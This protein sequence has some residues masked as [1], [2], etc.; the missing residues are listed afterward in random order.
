MFQK[1]LKSGHRAHTKR[2]FQKLQTVET[3]GP[4]LEETCKPSR[5]NANFLGRPDNE[6]ITDG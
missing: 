4:L 1:S 2:K 6:R 3:G 5:Q